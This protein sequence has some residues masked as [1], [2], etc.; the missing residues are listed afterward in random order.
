VSMAYDNLSEEE[1]VK[2]FRGGDKNAEEELLVRYKN[3]VLSIA[4]KFF[5]VG[6]DTDDL[7][8][9]GMFGLF[10]A[11][12]SF[13]GDSGFSAYAYACVRNRILDAV[14]KSSSAKNAA[15]NGSSP[16]S[17]ADGKTDLTDPEEMLIDSENSEEI[18]REMK[19]VLS[20]LEYSAIRMY[21]DGAKTSEIVSSLNITYK[22]AD[23]A[24]MR[25]KNKLRTLYAKR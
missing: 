15:L 4:R 6:G 10:A 1:L 23:N 3:K 5:L 19:S 18:V 13:E 24:V 17:A 11:M 22:Q 14:R 2:A 21:I 20:E 8:Q 9:E 16:I 7:V 12:T 25:A